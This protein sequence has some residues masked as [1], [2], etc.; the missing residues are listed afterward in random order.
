MQVDVVDFVAGAERARGVAI[1]IDVFRACSFAAYALAR[2]AARIVPVGPIDAALTFGRAHP[3]WLLCGERH[4]RTLDGFACGNSP[5]ELTRFDLRGRTLV[6]TTHAGTQ[7]LVAAA[8]RAALFTGA[9][10]NLSATAAAVRAL[11]PQHV[12]LVRMGKAAQE[13]CDED[14]LCAELLA[15]ALRGEPLR[16]SAPRIR[17]ALRCAPAAGKFFDPAATWA[18]EQDFWY[19]TDLDALDFAVRWRRDSDGLGVLTR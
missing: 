4:A 6:H 15:R 18:P 7:G 13:R 19:C 9:L 1:V 5:T 11:Q 3:E 16:T 10:V 8:D 12:T 2:G 17:T 14:D